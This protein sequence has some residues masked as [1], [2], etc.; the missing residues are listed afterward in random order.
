[1]P[2]RA[3]AREPVEVFLGVGPYPGHDR[4]D[5]S[6][7]RSASSSLH[8]GFRTRHRQPGPP[9]HRRPACARRDGAPRAPPPRSAHGQGSSPATH[10]ASRNTGTV[11]QSRPRHRRRP[12]PG[13]TRTPCGHTGRSDAKPHFVAAPVPPP[14]CH[15][16]R[17]PPRTPRTRCPRSR[18]ARPHPAA[19][20]I[21]SHC[22]RR[23][24]LPWFL[25]FDKPE[26]LSD[27]DVRPLRPETH[28]RKRQK[29]RE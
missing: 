2:M 24:P 20:A 5:A 28:P 15:R 27:N 12:H 3:Q 11:P 17:R 22:A 13:H 8:R 25:T 6:A 16:R 9:C 4:P 21:T 23:C 14:K 18:C 7:R 29:S 26:T 19:P 1:M 10:R